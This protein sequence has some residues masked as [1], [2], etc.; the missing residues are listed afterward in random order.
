[1]HAEIRVENYNDLVKISVDFKIQR[2]IDVGDKISKVWAFGAAQGDG[3]P[4]IFYSI[5]GKS[6]SDEIVDDGHTI[7]GS[8]DFIN[9]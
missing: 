1:M 8:I 7:C 4:I 5:V 9:K 6:L 3:T 2:F